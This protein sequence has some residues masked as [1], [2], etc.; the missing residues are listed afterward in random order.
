MSETENELES[1][2]AQAFRFIRDIQ[3]LNTNLQK[4]GERINQIEQ[5]ANKPKEV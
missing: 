3:I 5:E 4:V 2:Q 1:L